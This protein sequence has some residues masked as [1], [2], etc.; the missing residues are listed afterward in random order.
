MDLVIIW[1]WWSNSDPLIPSFRS[2]SDKI[3]FDLLQLLLQHGANPNYKFTSNDFE[4][5]KYSIILN[6]GISTDF[7]SNMKLID[8]L[9]QYQFDFEK[10]INFPDA[11]FNKSTVFD[12]LCK[13][14]DVKSV[15]RILNDFKQVTN[16]DNGLWVAFQGIRL[17]M[18]EYLLE[19]VY[20]AED[21]QYGLQILNLKH[22]YG[23]TLLHACVNTDLSLK[24]IDR[25]FAVFKLLL[26]YNTVDCLNIVDDQGLTVID[27]AYSNNFID[28]LRYALS[29]CFAKENLTDYQSIHQHRNDIINGKKLKSLI[30]SN[31]TDKKAP[32][33]PN[34]K[35]LSK[36]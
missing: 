25:N 11:V 23:D 34:V 4:D 5:V 35:N 12:I 3:D 28:F 24:G 21:K 20:F 19:K 9:Q 16:T 1:L 29:Y 22:E 13:H 2:K 26:K 30:R 17:E 18:M 6:A 33:I 36:I 32:R 8:I 14:G 27:Y 15:S 31:N 10:W 7:E